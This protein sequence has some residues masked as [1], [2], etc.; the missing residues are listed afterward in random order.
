[1]ELGEALIAQHLREPHE[2][3]WLDIHFFGQAGGG[4]ERDLVGIRHREAG[5]L[6]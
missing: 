4:A 2:R 1:L 3:R 6:G 5:D